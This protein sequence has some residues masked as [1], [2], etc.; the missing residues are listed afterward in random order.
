M[1]RTVGAGPGVAN[2]VQQPEEQVVIVDEQN[3]VVCARAASP[4]RA[5]PRYWLAPDAPRSLARQV[6]AATRAEMRARNLP[7]RA[8][9]VFLHNAAGALFVQQRVA[10]KETYP[11]HYD[12]APVR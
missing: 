4:A 10:W 12:P 8:S 11:S 1:E 7:H 2:P 5:A 9:F 6:G 3:N